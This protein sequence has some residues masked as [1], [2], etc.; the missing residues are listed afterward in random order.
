MREP[1]GQGYAALEERAGETQ[2]IAG[3]LADASKTVPKVP[4]E[5]EDGIHAALI[6][7]IA[8]G[9]NRCTSCHNKADR[10]IR[11]DHCPKSV[12]FEPCQDI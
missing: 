11:G 12:V 10:I 2:E 7:G 1:F 5:V 8:S 9:G 6:A 4:E 3:H